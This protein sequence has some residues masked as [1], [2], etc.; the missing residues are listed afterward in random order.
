VI[1]CP[2]YFTLRVV[3]HWNGLS[4][5]AVESPSLEIFETH[6]DEALCSLC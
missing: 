3:E 4:R 2:V 5:G 1:Y 6:L